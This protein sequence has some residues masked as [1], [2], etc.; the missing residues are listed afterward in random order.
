M[1]QITIRPMASADL[2]AVL[3][4]NNDE[5][6]AVGELDESGLREL[7]GMA[8]AVL[9]AE[10]DGTLAGFVIALPPDVA[11]TSS[12][13]R[14]LS[15]RYDDF[16][17]IDRVVVMPGGR[18]V[19][20]GRRLYDAVVATTTAATLLAEVNTRPRNDASLAFHERYGFLPVGEAEP[21][22]DGIA[23]RYLAKPL[24]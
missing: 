20:V 17:Y 23:V 10:I 18:G 2:P 9:A 22:G 1:S 7:V 3:S 19:G 13:Y 24:R 15:Q 12:N 11:Y 6:P 5:V 4:A 8:G 16:L 21:Y 14:W